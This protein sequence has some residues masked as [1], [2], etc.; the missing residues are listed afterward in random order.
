MLLLKLIT[1]LHVLVALFMILVVLLQGG[2]SGGVSATFGGGNS[3]G[4][5]GATGATSILTKLTYVAAVIFM[6]T[7]LSLS[8]IQSKAGSVGIFDKMKNSSSESENVQGGVLD[9]LDPTKAPTTTDA[10]AEEA[11][12]TDQATKATDTNAKTSETTKTDEAKDKDATTKV[13]EPATDKKASTTKASE[14]QQPEAK[15]EAPNK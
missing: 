13:K 15:K 11:S 6:I 1:A 8:M 2:S 14:T 9:H 5:F 10:A 4:V 7:S 12:T 3:S